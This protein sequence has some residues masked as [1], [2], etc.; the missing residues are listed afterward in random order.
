MLSFVVREGVSADAGLAIRDALDAEAPDWWSFLNPGSFLVFF[1][2][3]NSGLMRAGRCR[4][5]IEAI[6]PRHDSLVGLRFGESEGP[7]IGTFDRHGRL[8]SMPMGRVV[9]E[10]MRRR[11]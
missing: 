2:S 6:R 10:A 11:S 3:A 8:T 4:A 9:N 1:L 7:L 5:A